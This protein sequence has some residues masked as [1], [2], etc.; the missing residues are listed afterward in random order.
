E[1][2]WASA[3]LPPELLP[4]A[5]TAEKALK[6]AVRES[7]IGL[8]D[9]LIRLGKESEAEIVFAVVEEH[10][11]PDGSVSYTQ[12]TRIILDRKT[13]H[14]TADDQNH[15]IAKAVESAFSRLLTAHTADD[16]RRLVI[17]TLGTFA[18]V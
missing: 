6:V 15:D 10:K 18:A 2:H 12:Q 8:H 13:E 14:V 4:E 16:V 9:R 7:A 11:H 17:R 3:N 5:P 1:A